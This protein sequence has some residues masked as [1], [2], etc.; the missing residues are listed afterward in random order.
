M[1]Q[2]TT[3]TYYIKQH[4]FTSIIR[5]RY[6]ILQYVQRLKGKNTIVEGKPVYPHM[7]LYTYERYVTVGTVWYSLCVCD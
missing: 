5:I 4:Q 7:V 1:I 3:H 2:N 6:Y